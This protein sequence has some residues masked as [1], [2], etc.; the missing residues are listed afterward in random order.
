MQFSGVIH[1]SSGWE[2]KVNPS[3]TQ[4]T[5]SRYVPS[6]VSLQ[7]QRF[8]TVRPL[9]VITFVI[10]NKTTKIEIFFFSILG[11]N[12]YSIDASYETALSFRI[13]VLIFNIFPVVQKCEPWPIA[14]C[15]CPTYFIDI[16]SP[17]I[18]KWFFEHIIVTWLTYTARILIMLYFALAPFGYFY[19]F[20]VLK[21]LRKDKSLRNQSMKITLR[22]LK[23]PDTTSKLDCWEYKG[24]YIQ[25]DGENIKTFVSIF[26][27]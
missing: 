8:N 9:R 22:T 24:I 27:H 2:E 26:I 13:A 7:S 11:D 5:T 3:I 25:F 19:F 6:L 16:T 17:Y 14:S 18:S 23:G 15:W 12:R 20:G 4:F 1:H 21:R 10:I